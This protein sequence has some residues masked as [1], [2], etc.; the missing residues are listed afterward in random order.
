MGDDILKD[1]RF[2]HLVDD[3]RYKYVPKSERKVKIDKRFQSMFKDKN[4]KVSY[5]I[6]KRGRPISKTSTEDLKKY[7]DLST[8][9][10]SDE[11][12]D[13][14]ETSDDGIE[15]NLLKNFHLVKK[16]HVNYKCNEKFYT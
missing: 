2:A 4:F 3:P 14:D 10:E 1:S 12:D 16:F 6:D 15:L 8:S 11:D 7:Y 13:K 9:S 5:T